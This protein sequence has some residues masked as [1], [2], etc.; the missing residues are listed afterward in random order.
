MG[1]ASPAGLD[2]LT[3]R[4]R[5][6]KEMSAPATNNP[7]STLRYRQRP[8]EKIRLRMADLASAVPTKHLL[9]ELPGEDFI[10]IDA[11]ASLAHIV[12]KISL[13]ELAEE[14]PDLFL[15]VDEFV[16]LPAHRV[17][18]AYRLSEESYEPAEEFA[19]GSKPT[20]EPSEDF[21]TAAQNLAR[22][23]LN[24]VFPFTEPAAEEESSPAPPAPVEDSAPASDQPQRLIELIHSLPTFHRFSPVPPPQTLIEPLILET[25]NTGTDIPEQE[26]LQAL[27]LTDEKLTVRRV[28][29]LCGELPGIRSCVLTRDDAV[30]ASHNVPENFDLVAMSSTASKMLAAMQESSSQ[31][32]IGA[33]PALTL[34]TERGPLSIVQNNRLTLLVV[35]ADRGFIPGVREKLT[36]TLGEL[37]RMPL[38]LP[39]AAATVGGMPLPPA[40]E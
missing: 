29:E 7:P 20:P 23:S 31:L 17:A 34:H 28:V 19:P 8:V 13:R 3:G 24:E 2:N 40:S 30:V 27:F 4:P 14:R 15:P 22:L 37:S 16:K 18:T 5:Q 10:E 36:S 26:S 21:T 35:H 25:E 6:P 1:I 11:R 33:V 9:R 12:P 38:A 39:S 32:G